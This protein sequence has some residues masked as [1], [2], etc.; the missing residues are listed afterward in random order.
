MKRRGSGSKQKGGQFERQ[1]CKQLSLWMSRGMHD[2]WFWRSAM[3]GGRATVQRRK[4]KRNQ[5]QVGDVSAI[6]PQGARL[7]DV[8]VIECKNVKDLALHGLFFD[9][10]YGALVD[11]WRELCKVAGDKSPMLIA[12]QNFFSSDE[13]LVCVDSFG[14]GELNPTLTVRGEHLH[15]RAGLDMYVF[16]LGY[17][18]KYGRRP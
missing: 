16:Q 3:S 5:T 7:T 17:V 1:V 15:L 9:P 13:A 6:H 12:R 14:A 4:G 10:P 2:D 8:F 11:Y 18:L